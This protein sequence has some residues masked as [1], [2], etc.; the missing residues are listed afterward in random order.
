MSEQF[1]L[2][3]GLRDGRTV[4]RHKR[5]TGPGALQMDCP[6]DKF[7]PRPVLPSDQHTAVGRSGRLDQLP[8][9]LHR[10]RLS[11]Q[12]E[13]P[14]DCRPECPILLFQPV[15]VQ[16]MFDAQRDILERQRLFNIV[17]RPQLDRLD[18]RFDRAVP[19]HHHHLCRRHQ[20]PNP[21]QG[22]HAIYFRHPDIE[23]HE[24]WRIR[25]VGAQRLH[26]GL[27]HCHLVPFI[28][29][30]AAQGCENRLFVIHN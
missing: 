26:A 17:I 2:D 23:E 12:L 8:Q 29:Q 21:A 19:G 4:H 1:T 20:L 28:P 6:R 3:Q 10:G 16:G 25:G 13:L 14:L 30:N 27:G 7:L 5:S 24:I 9:L 22:F 15:L 18:R 11:H